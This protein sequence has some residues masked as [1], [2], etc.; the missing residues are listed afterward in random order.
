[1][2]HKEIRTYIIEKAGIDINKVSLQVWKLVAIC[3]KY[4]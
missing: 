1:M 4:L 3:R 2:Y